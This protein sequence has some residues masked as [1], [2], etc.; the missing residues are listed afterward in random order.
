MKLRVFLRDRMQ[1]KQGLMGLQG[2]LCR[3]GW[4]LIEDDIR[5]GLF[6]NRWWSTK[7]CCPALVSQPPPHSSLLADIQA[8]L[9]LL[10][11]YVFIRL[12]LLLSVEDP[13]VTLQRAREIKVQVLCGGQGPP[14]HTKEVGFKD[15]EINLEHTECLMLLFPLYQLDTD[16]VRRHS[17][18]LML[19]MVGGARQHGKN[20]MALTLIS[21]VT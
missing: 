21:L 8:L 7:S 18:Q 3:F 9:R 16:V 4:R 5:L 12:L 15:V 17:T 2:D 6:L 19:E 11:E 14:R 10:P 1:S 13:H 20:R